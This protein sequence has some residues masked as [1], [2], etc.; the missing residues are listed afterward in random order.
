MKILKRTLLVGTFLFLTSCSLNNNPSTSIPGGSTDNNSSTGEDDNLTDNSGV[1]LSNSQ[2]YLTFWNPSSTLSFSISMSKD[3]AYKIST[4]QNNST[5]IYADYYFPCSVTFTVNGIENVYEEVGIRMKGNTSRREFVDSNGNFTDKCH[6]KLKFNETFDGSEYLEVSELQD[7][8]HEWTDTNARKTRKS[9]NVFD[10]QKLNIKW[11]KNYDATLVKE[12]YA[13]KVFRDNGVIAPRM[14]ISPTSISTLDGNN[15]VDTINGTYDIIEEVDDILISRYFSKEKASGD[16]YK[17]SWSANLSSNDSVGSEIG[18]ENFKTNFHPKYDLKTNKKKSNHEDL[19][20]FIKV[21]NSSTSDRSTY[22]TQ[23]EKVLNVKNFLN[24]EALAYLI[25]NPDDYRN[26][27]NNTYI[28]FD[29]VN[30][31]CHFIPYDFDRCFGIGVDWN[32]DGEWLKQVSPFSSKQKGN[33]NSNQSNKLYLK[34]VIGSLSKDNGTVITEYLT[35]YANNIKDII[36]NNKISVESFTSYVNSFPQSYRGDPN[37]T[38][39]NKTD[40]VKTN[41]SFKDYFEAKVT[42]T[43]SYIEM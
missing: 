34:T 5:S 21:V 13:Y 8:Y 12:A 26:N 9:R 14:T 31:K 42:T 16:L 27:M 15:V 33:N 30:H 37:G 10:M 29:S 6:F 32:P 3:V 43:K 25:G 17:L 22:K 41:I 4:L 1:A 19:L 2:E 11:N 23:L 24:L 7:Y 40:D 28:Y 39:L 35:E 18:V 38:D 36:Q 20:N